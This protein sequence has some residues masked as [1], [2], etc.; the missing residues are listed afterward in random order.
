MRFGSYASEHRR[1]FPTIGTRLGSSS[2]RGPPITMQV[3][4]YYST[5]PTDSRDTYCTEAGDTRFAKERDADGISYSFS[6]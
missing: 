1:P 5:Q 4:V 2:R 6:T 3:S